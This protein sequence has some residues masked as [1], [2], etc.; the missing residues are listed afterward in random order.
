VGCCP[1][2]WNCRNRW[3][4]AI[5][6]T[7]VPGMGGIYCLPTSANT[8]VNAEAHNPQGT[9]GTPLLLTQDGLGEERHADAANDKLTATALFRSPPPAQG[10]ERRSGNVTGHTTA[11]DASTGNVGD[12]NEA[13]TDTVGDAVDAFTGNDDKFD[14]AL[15]GLYDDA[16][17]GTQATGTSV[18]GNNDAPPNLTHGETVC[19]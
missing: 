5:A 3:S 10:S 9:A 14:N 15:T 19:V 12:V 11:N 18:D 13:L 8:T 4:E 16:I 6:Q 1:G 2:E 7:P 17:L